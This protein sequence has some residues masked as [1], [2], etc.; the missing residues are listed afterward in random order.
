MIGTQREVHYIPKLQ[1][2]NSVHK[3]YSVTTTTTIIFFNDNDDNDN[4]NDKDSDNKKLIM[5]IKKN[6]QQY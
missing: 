4:A 2:K 5:M 1:K 3:E 6:L